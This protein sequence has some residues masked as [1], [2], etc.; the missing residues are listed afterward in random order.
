[1]APALDLEGQAVVDDGPRP[2]FVDG[3]R[4]ECG[5]HVEHGERAAPARIAVGM[6]DGLR[7][8]PSNTAS[9]IASARSAALAILVSRSAS[10]VVVKRMALA[11]VWRWMKRARSRSFPV[12]AA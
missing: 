8:Q 11:M 2:T 1:M 5:R 7:D 4:G 12:S 3:E 6:A 9:S 10:S